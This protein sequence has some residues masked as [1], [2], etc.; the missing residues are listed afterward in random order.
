MPVEETKHDLLLKRVQIV[1]AILGG[2]AALAVGVYNVKKSYFEKPAE[3]VAPPPPP[4]QSDK[5]R[6]T[7]E[8]VGASWLETLKKKQGQ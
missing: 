4:Q 7:L 6:S 5:L 3:V 2:L 8:D 1:I